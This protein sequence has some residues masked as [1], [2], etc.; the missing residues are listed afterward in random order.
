MWSRQKLTRVSPAGAANDV[1]KLACVLMR[2]SK[3]KPGKDVSA[4]EC[5]I[6]S[7]QTTWYVNCFSLAHMLDTE[8]CVEWLAAFMR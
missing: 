4:F 8:N 5:C 1:I 3:L 6:T 2:R 7:G